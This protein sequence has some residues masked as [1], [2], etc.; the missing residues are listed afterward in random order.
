[1]NNN[2]WFNKI[3]KNT[4]INN[5]NKII[6]KFFK[7]DAAEVKPRVTDINTLLN[8]VK[9]NQE[10]ESKKKLYFSVAASSGLLLFGF[11]IF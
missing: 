9:L 5:K 8:R 7:K 10:K 1:M 6:S 11:L 4:G 2:S 3:M